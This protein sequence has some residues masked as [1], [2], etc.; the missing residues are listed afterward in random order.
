MGEILTTRDAGGHIYVRSP[1]FYPKWLH[2]CLSSLQAGILL[3]DREKCLL[4][5]WSQIWIRIKSLRF[6]PR[7]Y[8]A[9]GL[10]RMN[11]SIMS[12]LKHAFG[13]Q[14]RDL[15][16]PYVQVSFAGL[17]VS[18]HSC[19]DNSSTSYLGASMFAKNYKVGIIK[20]TLY[21][22]SRLGLGG[23]YYQVCDKLDHRQTTYYLSIFVCEQT[24]RLFPN[25]KLEIT[26]INVC[27]LL[28]FIS[29]NAAGKN[30]RQKE[31][32]QTNVERADCLHWDVPSSLSEN[33]DP[34]ERKWHGRNQSATKCQVLI[35]DVIVRLAILSSGPTMLTCPQSL[36]METK[37]TVWQS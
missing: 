3:W 14:T 2:S 20:Q 36:M 12:N 21:E 16:N 28:F 13:A 27:L 17:T 31:Q 37:V 9:D 33:Q 24:T 26:M 32:L 7:V 19:S 23:G 4:M 10:P 1:N 30:H 34:A 25:G 35:L 18:R 29:E 6:S 5:G 8:R 15:V 22:V 11:S